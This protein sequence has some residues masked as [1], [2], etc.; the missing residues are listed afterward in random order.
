MSRKERA[1]ELLTLALDDAR[2]WASGRSWH[3]RAPV[4]LYLAYA[5]LRHVADREYGSWFAGITFGIHELGHVVFAW[6]WKFLAIAGGTIAQLGAPLAAAWTL[7]KQRDWF[8]VAVGLAWLSF[9]LHDVAR[10]A[11]DARARRLP[12]LGLTDD[13]IHDWHY[14]LSRLHLLPLDTTL[15]FLLHALA[16]LVWAASIGFGGWLLLV[17]AGRRT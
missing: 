7:L 12:L 15:A 5:G 16:F 2:A 8:G 10:Y 4:L 1:K 14:M 17:M 11:G 9:S 13:P 3:W 6:G